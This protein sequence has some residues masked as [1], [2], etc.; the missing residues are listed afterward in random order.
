MTG[1]GPAREVISVATLAAA[2]EDA[3]DAFVAGHPAASVYH[4]RSWLSLLRDAFGYQPRILVARDGPGRL[5]GALPLALVRTPLGGRRLVSLPFSHRVAPLAEDEPGLTA[6]LAGAV[7][8]AQQ[9]G[10]RFAELRTGPLAHPPA[11]LLEHGEYVSTSLE[12]QRDPEAQLERLR[13]NTRQ[14]LRQGLKQDE[15]AFREGRGSE[16][17]AQLQRLLGV[18]R[19]R[20]GSLSYPPAFY[21]AL[22][23]RLLASGAARLDLAFSKERCVAALVTLCHGAQ[24][25]Y[26]YGASLDEPALLR[27]RPNNVLLW[28]GIVWA[29]QRGAR[30]FDMGTSL[31]SQEGLVF[32]K[33]GYGG[34]TAPL[35]YYRWP[36]GGSASRGVSQGGR[37]ARMAGEVLKRLPQPVFDRL[38]PFLLR[39]LG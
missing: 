9:A 11:E 20:L 4:T 5:L 27:L 18:S 2:D 26:G 12:L 14:Q 17:V 33:E 3:Y 15:L 31:P 7:R 1:G 36:K 34:R 8:E 37:V 10:C 35:P 16:D 25:I 24:A 6:L 29:I 22:A 30:V 13:D 38:A 23:E 39:Q 19:R 28:R 21:R 32:F